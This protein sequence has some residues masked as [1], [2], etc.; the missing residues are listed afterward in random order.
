MDEIAF[1]GGQLERRLPI[2]TGEKLHLLGLTG[3]ANVRNKQ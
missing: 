2:F 3:T 1:G